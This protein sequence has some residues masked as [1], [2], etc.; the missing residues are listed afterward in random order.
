[1]GDYGC[2]STMPVGF[3][4]LTAARSAGIALVDTCGFAKLE[5]AGSTRQDISTVRESWHGM[6]LQLRHSKPQYYGYN[7]T[8]TRAGSI[9][10][11]IDVD[12]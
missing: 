7:T 10:H 6:A 9:R 3:L 11:A 2:V 12:R 8:Q 4:H 5:Q 1:M